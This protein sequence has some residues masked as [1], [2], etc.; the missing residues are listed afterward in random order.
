MKDERMAKGIPI[1]E[2]V[3]S[4]F[5]ALGSEMALPFPGA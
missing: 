2:A 3:V 1:P 5:I 4:D